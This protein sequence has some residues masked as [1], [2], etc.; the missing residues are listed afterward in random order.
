[1]KNIFASAFGH[2]T[3]GVPKTASKPKAEEAPKD[4]EETLEDNE[5]EGDDEEDDEEDPANPVDENAED[6]DSEE[7]KSAARKPGK[8]SKALRAAIAKGRKAERDRCAA[9]FASPHAAGRE[10]MA[11]QLA[12]STNLNATEAIAILQAT[13]KGGKADDLASRMATVTQPTL[14]PGGDGGA[15]GSKPGA[16]LIENAKKRA[17]AAKAAPR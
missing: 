6:E 17:A 15:G 9:I 14:G 13:P 8:T 4:E 7:T 12:F 5:S 3:G 2:L 16:S 10:A 1:M 11:A